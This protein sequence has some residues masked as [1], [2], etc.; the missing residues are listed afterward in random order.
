MAQEEDKGFFDRLG[1][2]LNAPL[3]G[4]Q[5]Q[6]PQTQAPAADDDD[7]SVLER[8]KDILNAPLPRAPQAESGSGAATA[9][10][11][12]AKTP[13]F[14]EDELDE[15]WWKQDWAAFRAHQEQERNGLGHKQNGDLEKF[16]AYQQQEKQRFDGHQQQELAAFINQQHRRLSAWNQAVANSPPGQKPPPPPWDMPAGGQRPPQGQPMPGGPRGGPPPWMRP[17]GGGRRRA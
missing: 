13:E 15:A 5:G 9:S 8:I 3:P 2:I 10:G 7:G 16:K 11:A 17:P 1:E 6:A 4:T 12:H 14:D